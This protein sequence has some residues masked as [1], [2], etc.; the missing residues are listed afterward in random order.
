MYWYSG[1]WKELWGKGAKQEFD[2]LIA[3]YLTNFPGSCFGLAERNELVGSMFLLK[4]SKLKPIPCIHKVPDYLDEKGDIAYVS[5]FV[6]K[7]G[8]NEVEIAEK[9]YEKAEEVAL[10]IGCKK[11]AVVIFNS[12]L[13]E[14]VLK[15][16]NYERSIEEYQWEIYPG[17]MVPCHI[18]TYSLLMDGSKVS[19]VNT[20]C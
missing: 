20:F 10:S 14:E 7:R 15:G 17:L 8:N 1:R 9:L 6:V 12:P 11:I 2:N 19:G 18:Y 4:V 16:N 13:E 5:L 3:D